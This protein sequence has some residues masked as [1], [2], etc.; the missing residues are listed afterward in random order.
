MIHETR[1]VYSESY[2]PQ[3]RALN[4][5]D[6]TMSYFSKLF[7]RFSKPPKAT[8]APTPVAEPVPAPPVVVDPPSIDGD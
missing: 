1:F 6:E 3:Y 4:R 7:A 8:T 2:E 5:G